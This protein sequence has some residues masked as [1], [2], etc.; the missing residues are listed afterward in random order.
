MP[1]NLKNNITCVGGG[2]TMNMVH[3]FVRKKSIL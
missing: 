2:V 3:F 1:E